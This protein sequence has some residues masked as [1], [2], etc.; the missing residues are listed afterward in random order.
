MEYTTSKNVMDLFSLLGV[1]NE[2]GAPLFIVVGG[3]PMDPN[4]AP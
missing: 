4:E 1:L 2:R 3:G